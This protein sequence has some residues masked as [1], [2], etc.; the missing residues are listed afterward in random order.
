MSE[1]E[2]SED[3]LSLD[4]IPD[5]KD[6]IDI[7]QIKPLKNNYEKIT[8]GKMEE[9]GNMLIKEL[10]YNNKFIRIVNCLYSQIE[11]DY[12]IS[13]NL[14][15]LV[16]VYIFSEIENYTSYSY[17]LVPNTKT[18]SIVKSSKIIDKKNNLT[19]KE[20]SIPLDK[21]KVIETLIEYLKHDY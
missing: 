14:V 1:S 11:L 12:F 15:P 2:N 5:K 18:Y 19:L 7:F 21:E 17:C 8:L 9:S 10:T 20:Y 13:I 4:N 3:F 6:L 16:E